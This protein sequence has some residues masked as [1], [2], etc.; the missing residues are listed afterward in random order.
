ME[1]KIGIIGKSTGWERV[2]SQIGIP[3]SI[4]SNVD[5]VKLNS[6]PIMVL[7]DDITTHQLLAVKKY[8]ETGGCVVCSAAVIDNISLERSKKD[9]IKYLTPDLMGAFADSENIDVYTDATLS[10][11]A[12]HFRTD[13]NNPAVLA[14]KFGDGFV[15]ILPFDIVALIENTKSKKKNFYTDGKRL[16][17]ETVSLV[18][19]GSLRRLITKS[20]EFIYAHCNLHFGH[21]WYYPDAHKSVFIFRVDTD[22]GTEEQ[23]ASLYKL[24]QKY[25]IP[26]TWF[27]DVKSQ[28]KWI[29]NY[30]KMQGQ[31]IGVHC[32]EHKVYE[33]YADNYSNI[34]KALEIIKTNG[35]NPKGFAAPF[36][37]W[38]SALGQAVRDLEFEYSSEFAYDYDNLPS[39][40]NY[41]TL[42]IPV[43]PI[44]IGSLR[45]QGYTAPQMIAY[46]ENEI[47]KK[48]KLSEPIILYHHPTNENIDVVEKIFQRLH[49]IDIP[50]LTMHQFA[51]WWNKRE[52]VKA[53]IQ[54]DGTIL[55]VQTEHTIPE[56]R[57]RLVSPAGKEIITASEPLIEIEKICWREKEIPLP[58][59]KDFHR[60]RKFNI[61]MLINKIEDYFF[62]S[63]K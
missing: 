63:R 9:F 23:V 27:V 50:K 8:I 37:K 56:M 62:T 3:F 11:G 6:F 24:S 58:L 57:L 14:S 7:S 55:N 46:Y 40:T 29:S 21:K 13:K 28:A 52:K 1:I 51:E 48:L 35:I 30:V 5:E 39:Y 36:G 53:M 41:S 43:H 19:K 31:E 10:E 45:R 18:S 26:I 59:P 61:W 32:Y 49:S 17:Y 4:C 54:Q 12:N 60:I 25:Q 42:Q 34:R 16:P 44:C 15:V 38:N 47:E 22:Y 33:S 2:L 20:I